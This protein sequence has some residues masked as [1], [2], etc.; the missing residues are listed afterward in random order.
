M[1]IHLTCRHCG[2]V[3]NVPEKYAGKTGKCPKCGER[4]RVI[5]PAE[6]P[7]GSEQP[8]R[9]EAEAPEREGE[10]WE[11]R[12]S[13]RSLRPATSEQKTLARELGIEFP[14]NISAHE[15]S[16]LIDGARARET[17]LLRGGV[18]DHLKTLVRAKPEEMLA[19]MERRGH[20]AV[21][22]YG[23][24]QDFLNSYFRAIGSDCLTLETM[25]RV[26]AWAVW[27]AAQ[28]EN[29]DLGDFFQKYL[30]HG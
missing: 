8:V 21:M 10:P 4:L 28:K 22:I 23:D 25:L 16:V 14:E 18:V 2:A 7:P 6:E 17:I 12:K 19:E 30:A 1:T 11:E 13:P 3:L 27:D 20:F 29:M 26:L 5:S 15:I 9:E 24:K